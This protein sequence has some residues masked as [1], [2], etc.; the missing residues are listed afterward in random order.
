M[1]RITVEELEK[2]ERCKDDKDRNC[3]IDI[4][5]KEAFEKGSFSNAVNI[6]KA[7]FEKV[8]F[9]EDAGYIEKT[10][11]QNLQMKGEEI[12]KA[13]LYML[14]HTGEQS[15]DVVELLTEAGYD[16]YNIEGGY[17][18]DRKSVV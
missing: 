15:R 14:C 7:V 18:S 2:I 13:R 11:Q 1:N 4:R 6:P 12:K 17:R 5:D 16:A 8:E 3:I 9:N 10:L